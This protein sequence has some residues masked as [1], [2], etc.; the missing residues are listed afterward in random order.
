M[1]AD[2]ATF[3]S[4]FKYFKPSNALVDIFV[5]LDGFETDEEKWIV[6]LTLHRNE[7]PEWIIATENTAQEYFVLEVEAQ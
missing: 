6:Q 3:N 1:G 2:L 7:I 5:G 4:H